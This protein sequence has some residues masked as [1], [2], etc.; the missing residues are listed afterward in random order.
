MQT[1]AS[2]R[3]Y[4]ARC[5]HWKDKSGN[6][7]DLYAGGLTDDFLS[8]CVKPKVKPK[9]MFGGKKEGDVIKPEGTSRQ[10]RNSTS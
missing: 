1:N 10:T 7:S 6:G 5:L 2:L 3:T 4:A 9:R 8:K